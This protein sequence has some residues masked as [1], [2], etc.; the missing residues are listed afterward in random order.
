MSTSEVRTTRDQRSEHTSG[1]TL[2]KYPY[3]TSVVYYVGEGLL[4]QVNTVPDPQRVDLDGIGFEFRNSRS[5]VGS[6]V[7]RHV[8]D[9]LGIQHWG[10]LEDISSSQKTQRVETT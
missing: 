6:S 10:V 5:L 3:S 9:D 4:K 2:H 8:P 7:F 1:K